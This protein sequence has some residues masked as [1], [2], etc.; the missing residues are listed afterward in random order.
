MIVETDRGRVRGAIHGGSLR[1]RGLRYGAAERFAAP[2][3][4][5]PWSGVDDAIRPGPSAPQKLLTAYD[6]DFMRWYSQTEPQSEDCLTLDLVTPACDAGRRPV[7][8]WLHGGGWMNFAATAPGFDASKLALAEGVVVVSPNHRLGAPGHL[9]IPGGCPSA[10]LLDLVLALDWVR[11]NASAF[12]GDPGNVCI[13]GQSGGASKVAALMA[14]A[15]AKGLFH[16]AIIQSCSGGIRITEPVESARLARGFA[17][18]AS[19]MPD[20]DSLRCLK[21]PQLQRALANAPGVFRPVLDGVQFTRHPFDPGP[22]PEAAGIPLMVGTTDTESTA[23]LYRDPANFALP[24]ASVLA[25]LARFLNAPPIEATRIFD[26]YADHRPDASPSEILIAVTTDQL[27]KRNTL[28]IAALQAMQAPVWAYVFARPTPVMGGHLRAPHCSELPFI[29]G[30]TEVAAAHVGQTRD[31][32]EITRMMMRTWGAFARSG[33]P[34]NETLPE[35]RRYSDS[36][37][38]VM[39]LAA[40]PMLLADPGGHARAA[41]DPLPIY[42]YGTSRAN[43]A[44]D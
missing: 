10:G 28:R 1:F 36:D 15:T 18:A 24:R 26:I 11:R 44:Q 19:A 8:V 42:E 25:R 14:M 12:G 16:K 35:W 7:M 33:T 40:E 20:A 43:F 38:P 4:P 34:A 5:A 39:R 21:V 2:G 30:T 17:N 31:I 27:F 32:P 41:L 9:D 29:F 23:Y 6:T 37:L 22:P 3:A 13:F